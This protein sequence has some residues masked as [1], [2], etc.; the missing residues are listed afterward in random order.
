MAFLG[1]VEKDFSDFVPNPQTR[2][3][4]PPRVSQ[5]VGPNVLEAGKLPEFP[6]WRP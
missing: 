5:A 6:G 4:P 3:M 2:K 1:V